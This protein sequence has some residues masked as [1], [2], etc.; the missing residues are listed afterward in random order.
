MYQSIINNSYTDF[1]HYTIC[2]KTM[3]INNMQKNMNQER[4]AMDNDLSIFGQFCIFVKCLH[5]KHS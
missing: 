3:N 4:P 2:S 5:S 1:K